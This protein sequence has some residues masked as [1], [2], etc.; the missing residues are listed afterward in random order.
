MVKD[1]RAKYLRGGFTLIELL[2]VMTIIA[3]LLSIAVPRYIGNIDRAKEAALRENLATLRDVLDKHFA[4]HGS[5][6]ET[7]DQLV[8]RRYLRKIPVDPFTESS[9]TW[10]I[11]PPEAAG[12][13]NV[14]DVHSSAPGKAKDGT[15][16]RE[17]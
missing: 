7:L 17:L 5:Y 8:A 4:D 12:K 14:F 11:V 1:V 15:P 2:V 16:L 10:T 6:P 3:A 13:G 9:A